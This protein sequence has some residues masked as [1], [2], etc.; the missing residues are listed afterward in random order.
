M[1]TPY[2]GKIAIWHVA[3]SWIGEATIEE[4]GETLNEWAPNLDAVFVKTSQ[5][6]QWQG[7][8]DSKASMAINGPDDLAKWVNVLAN[9]DLEVHAWCVPRGEDVEKEIDLIVQASQVPGVRSMILDVE[10][11]DGFW[12]G[13]KEDVTTLCS[14]IRNALGQDFHIG[15]SVDPRTQWYKPIYPDAWRPYVDSIHPQC[16][17]ALM[18][19]EPESVISEAY[20]VW[21]DYG[22]PV[23]PLLQAWD[24]Y[25]DAMR[26]AHDIAKGV[27]GATGISWFRLGTAGPIQWP[28]IDDEIVDSEVGPDDIVRFYDWEKIVTPDDPG[29]M[30][31]THTG[32]PVEQEFEEFTSVRGHTVRYKPTQELSDRVLAQWV[33]RLP[34]Q[35]IYEVSV[36]IPSEHATTT[37]AQYHIHGI[38]SLEGSEL[39]VRFNQSRYA[40]QWVPLVVYEFQEGVNGG[41]VNLTDLTGEDDREIAF[42]AVRWR[43][44]V[45]QKPIEEVEPPDDEEEEEEP[46]VP[47]DPTQG[48]DAPVGTV[49]E[50]L[51]TKVWPSTWYDATGYATYYTVVGP[52][53][54][55]GV[56]LNNNRPTWDSDREAPVYAPAHGIVTYSGNLG[57]TWQHVIVIRH[58]PLPNGDIV[59]TRYA[60]VHQPR[61]SEGQRVER[62]EQIAVI[63]NAY[64]RLA[65]HL[66]Y[67]IVKTNVLEQ[68]PGHWP[69]LNLDQV[70]THYH[71][72]KSFTISHRPPVRG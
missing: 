61:V 23:Y 21:G 28:A 20:V 53:Y 6:D 48:F 4:V 43:R 44:V 34:T 68:Y 1:P 26:E 41:R 38:V 39:L 17:W 69:G 15:M 54:H 36:Y 32:T 18:G 30:S 33:P 16:Y 5:G 37:E 24:V 67:D 55:T 52:A 7:A 57:G 27:R 60:H 56:D 66:H 46:P 11:F 42:G 62:G 45:E 35:G 71:N 51:T 64:G 9:F 50:R 19:R 31:G 8:K 14:G 49:E 2:D 22:L 65:Y 13:T 12:K 47:G 59:W 3:G 25:A 10:P 72:P 40:N 63:G 58:D 29:Y 70:Y